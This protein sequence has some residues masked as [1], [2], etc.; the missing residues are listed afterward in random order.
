L[1]DGLENFFLIREGFMAERIS[2]SVNGVDEKGAFGPPEA[3]KFRV[4]GG[5][6]RCH[7]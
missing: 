7:H 6:N 2:S 4:L 5:G 1:L 3:S